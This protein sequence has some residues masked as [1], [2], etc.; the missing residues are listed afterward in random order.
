MVKKTFY[1]ILLFLVLLI[2]V[3]CTSQQE[4]D[5]HCPEVLVDYPQSIHLSIKD[6]PDSL[7]SVK[8]YVLLDTTRLSC[9]FGHISKVLQKQGRI[10][11][12]D[13]FLM[14]LVV[15]DVSGKGIGQLGRRGQGPGEYL[16]ITD[17]DVSEDGEVYF[18]D[19]NQDKLFHFDKNLDFVSS[20]A[21][22]FEAEAV[23][24]LENGFLFGLSSFNKG[25][26]GEGFKVIRT[27]EHFRVQQSYVRF[28]EFVDPSY[29]FSFSSFIETSNYLVY[30][31]PI[32][33][34]VYLF[35]KKG[36]LMKCLNFDFGKENVPDTYKKDVERHLKELEN[37]CFLKKFVVVTEHIISGT[38]RKG[39]KSVP[40]IYD[41]K[42]NHCFHYPE[43]EHYDNRQ[44]T[45]FFGSCM[46][47]YYEP[48]GEYSGELPDSVID[49][50]NGKGYVLKLQTLQ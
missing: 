21:L 3:R 31:Y 2:H 4:V 15:Y 11:I 34:H 1:A 13:A 29:S 30:N 16:Q 26:D 27:D 50:L 24:V 8:N 7:L 22:P 46:F 5:S 23:H 48:E 19:G 47:S 41:L 37:C 28:D 39:S 10:Y 14:K 44:L 25:N 32:D 42:T 20:D 18:I 40:F 6:I 9:D 38:F 12:W 17:F 33:N 49:Y 43:T 35:D 45:G 36:N